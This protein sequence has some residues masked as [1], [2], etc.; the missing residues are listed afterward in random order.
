MSLKSLKIEF[1][2]KTPQI[3]LEPG[4]IQIVGRSISENPGECYRPVYEWVS[5]YAVEG[6]RMTDILLGFE[7]I[8]TTSMMWVYSIL[9]ELA[10]IPDM[11]VRAKISWYYEE[12]DEDMRDL[13]L[14]LR[15]L[16]NCPF[17]IV[18]V[19]DI[20]KQMFVQD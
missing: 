20:N 15:S 6:M 19:D 5:E 11:P 14:I 18:E 7:F 8:N 9:K 10:K 2:K 13:G 4:R 1:T 17:N 3:I 16:V 12:G